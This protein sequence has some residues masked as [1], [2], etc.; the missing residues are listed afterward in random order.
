MWLEKFLRNTA[1]GI[2]V[3]ATLTLAFSWSVDSEV[4]IEIKRFYTFIF[5]AIISLIAATL[6]LVG[7]FTN[8]ENQRHLDD[9]ARHRKLNAAKA[10]LPHALSQ[11]C[12]V[13]RWGM[14]YSHSFNYYISDLGE[15]P[16]ETLSFSQLK[17]S[18]E[19][20]SVF[21]DLIELS[22]DEILTD[23]LAGI[24]RE[25]Q[26]FLARWQDEFSPDAAHKVVSDADIRQ[27]TT[28]WAYLYAITCSLFEYA[29]NEHET[30]IETVSDK[31]ISSALNQ[32][33]DPKLH[34]EDFVKEVGLYTRTFKRRFKEI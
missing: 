19:V 8:I 30:L 4:S 26:V 14:R 25:H 3:G 33:G 16:F 23:R 6:T 5:T 18:D 15:E 1:F 2:F 29:R 12:S 27:R 28:G 34:N 9:E 32:S 22:D 11:M 24:L 7:V 10:L 17:L 20:I 13:C 21:R 31:E